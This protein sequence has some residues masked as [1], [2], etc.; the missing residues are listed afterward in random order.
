MTTYIATATTKDGGFAKV[1]K[2]MDNINGGK[3]FK[4]KRVAAD[5]A[6]AELDSGWIVEIYKLDNNGDNGDMV[7]RFKIR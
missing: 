5:T 3:R 2:D 4:S 1:G 6:R 7:Y